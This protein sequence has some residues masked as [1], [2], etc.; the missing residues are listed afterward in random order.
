[1]ISENIILKIPYE[2]AGISKKSGPAR[3]TSYRLKQRQ[4]LNPDAAR[5]AVLICPGGGYRQVSEREGEPVAIQINAMGYHAFVLD[6]S[7]G[8]ERFP[9]QLMEAASGVALIRKKSRE[10]NVDPDKI[11]IMGFSAGGHL[12]C[13]LGV[14]WNQEF[15]Q[16]ALSL[17]K[18]AIRPNGLILCYPVITS[19]KYA[20][21]GS[22]KHLLGE[23]K[24]ELMELVSLENQVGSHVP[25]TF[26]W[27]TYTD[28][29]VPVENSFLLAAALRNYNIN[30][31]M[32]IYPVG[33]HGLSLANEETKKDDGMGIEPQCQSWIHLLEIWLKNF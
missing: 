16:E 14:F 30:L 3:M 13:S 2:K 31:E 9:T 5:P 12:A 10:W 20:H 19:G 4:Y 25:K 32:H 29:A 24:K 28:L 8:E 17:P 21:R 6:Y 15:L 27:H 7:V 22:F 26:L 23:E 18:V 33:S 11:F 1:M